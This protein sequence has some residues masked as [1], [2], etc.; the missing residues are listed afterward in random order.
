MAET[1]TPQALKD[2]LDADPEAAAVFERLPTS[3]R[4]EYVKWIDEAKRP[5]TARGRAAQAIERLK[6]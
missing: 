6:A 5:E 2:A 1:E 3:H 4:A